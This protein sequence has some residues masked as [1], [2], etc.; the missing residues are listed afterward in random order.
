M[1]DINDSDSNKIEVKA[2][3]NAL[4]YLDKKISLF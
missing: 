4:I 3:M 1:E 2:G